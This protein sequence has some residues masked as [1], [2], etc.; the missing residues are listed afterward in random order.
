MNALA[1]ESLSS[2]QSFEAGVVP[3]SIG[4]VYEHEKW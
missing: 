4:Y 2:V 1:E 3:H